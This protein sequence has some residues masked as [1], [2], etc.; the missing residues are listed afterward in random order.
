MGANGPVAFDV[1]HEAGNPANV[2]TTGGSLRMYC[3]SIQ[4]KIK[5]AATTATAFPGA[6]L[7]DTADTANG[8]SDPATRRFLS[9]LWFD[10]RAI[11]RP[12]RT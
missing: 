11:S 7:Q 2:K 3:D 1:G 5:V 10:F 6:T 9:T 8:E 4:L 12:A